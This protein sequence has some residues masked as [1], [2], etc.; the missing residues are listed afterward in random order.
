MSTPRIC[1]KSLT[2]HYADGYAA[3]LT[4]SETAKYISEENSFT[5]SGAIAKLQ[6][7][8]ERNT[9]NSDQV[10][11]GIVS[12]SSQEFIGY[13]AA[14]KIKNQ[15]CPISYAVLPLHRRKGVAQAAIT[16]LLDYLSKS[17]EVKYAEALTHPGNT[18]SI[19]TLQA[20]GFTLGDSLAKNAHD[21]T[22]YRKR[23]R[24]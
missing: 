11:L 1:L 14:H 18:G 23:I 8:I 2:L 5:H 3:L 20:C 9:A 15:V 17:T 19:T 10:Y 12:E 24:V 16:L 4:D 13:V 22:V 6:H 21:R 7:I